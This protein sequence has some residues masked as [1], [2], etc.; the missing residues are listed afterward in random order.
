LLLV[1]FQYKVLDLHIRIRGSLS[2]ELRISFQSPPVR[3]FFAFWAEILSPPRI[4]SYLDPENAILPI[5]RAPLKQKK[6]LGIISTGSPTV[7]KPSS[8]L[9]DMQGVQQ[10]NWR[11]AVRQHC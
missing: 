9:G 1:Q 4:W 6:V 3:L 8:V 5:H 11:S 7:L 2:G 10:S